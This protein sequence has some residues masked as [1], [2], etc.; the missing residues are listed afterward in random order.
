MYSKEL[1]LSTLS[2]AELKAS[3]WVLNAFWYKKPE[4][5]ESCL[6]VGSVSVSLAG[7][8]RGLC[9]PDCLTSLEE[10]LQSVIPGAL[11]THTPKIS[12][13]S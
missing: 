11:W 13:M 4:N 6:W 7:G 2:A 5:Y 9:F 8:G 12:H 1:Y 3:L 10:R